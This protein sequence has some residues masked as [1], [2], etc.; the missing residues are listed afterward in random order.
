MK[1]TVIIYYSQHHGNTRKVLDSLAVECDVDICNIK[2]ADQLAL[3]EYK[4]VA[5]ASGIYFSKVSDQISLYIN[6]NK[7]ILKNKR[8][9]AIITA[10]SSGIK[11]R[12]RLIKELEDVGMQVEGSFQ[13]YG[14]DTYGPF[15]LIG[16]IRKMH[17]TQKD[18]KAAIEFCKK[19]T[20]QGE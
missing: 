14:Y 11:G 16:G 19:I 20:N 3:N 15:R 4:T 9:F 17:P 1:D 2:D 10:G 18:C 7:N 6:N 12:K 5:F 8:T 13:C